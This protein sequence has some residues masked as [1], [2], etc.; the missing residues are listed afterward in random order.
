MTLN[1]IRENLTQKISSSEKT[2]KHVLLRALKHVFP[3]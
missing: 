3:K 1:M 2:S